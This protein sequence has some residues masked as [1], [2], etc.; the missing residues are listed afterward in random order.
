MAKRKKTGG[1]SLGTGNKVSSELKTW[2]KELIDNNRQ[3]VEADLKELEPK[4]R[5]TI[6]EKFI[7]YVIPKQKA[8]DAKINF[9]DLSETDLNIIINRLA[10]G[11]K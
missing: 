5:I 2:I 4:D 3:T 9:E 11:L 7:S 10:E 6:I 8:I 1:R